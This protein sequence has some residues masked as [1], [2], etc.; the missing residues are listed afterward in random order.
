MRGTGRA[1]ALMQ[2]YLPIAEVSVDIFVLLGIGMAVGFL[3]S[4]F[5]VGGGFLA[6]PL[7]IF[8][9]VPP[10]VAV[11]TQ[12]NQIVGASLSGALAHWRRGNVDFTMAGVLLAGGLVGSTAGVGLFKLLKTHGQIDVVILISYVIF[13]GG[14]GGLMLWESIRSFVRMRRQPGSRAKLH[15]HIWLHGLPLKVRFRKSKLYISIFLPLGLGFV[16][17]ILAAL[18]GVGG[19]FIMV[20]AMIYILGMPTAMVIGT[21]LM[22]IIFVAMN[23]T[24]LQSVTTHTVDL[25]LAVVLL[26][27]GMLGARIGAR[28]GT[29][30]RGEQVRIL[31]ALVVVAVC[32]NLAYELVTTP[33]TPYSLQ[34]VTPP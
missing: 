21:S 33:A 5:G 26:A 7:L 9:G 25:M 24:I 27:G 32:I 17:G 13:L 11:A 4:L 34:V 3:S 28:I 15:Q 22:Q 30:L 2:I 20:P 14:I 23:V 31:L 19:G 29:N 8:L 1:A 6:T 18:M 12:A 16:V 10:P